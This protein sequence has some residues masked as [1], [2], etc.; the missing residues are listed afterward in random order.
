MTDQKQQKNQPIEF[1]S[2]KIQKINS[3]WLINGKTYAEC[4]CMEKYLFD[5][6]LHYQRIGEHPKK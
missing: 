5:L 3:H 1:H 6:F 4:G 2:L